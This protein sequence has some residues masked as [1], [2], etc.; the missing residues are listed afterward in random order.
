MTL[1][2]AADSEC[3]LMFI[4]FPSAKDPSWEQKFP[5]KYK[6]KNDNNKNN[7]QSQH[8]QIPQTIFWTCILYQFRTCTLILVLLNRIYP[9]FTNSVDP[10]QKPTGMDLHC[11]SFSI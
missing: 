3:P 7:A 9:A 4:S 8:A 6:S 10:D 1:E 11:L 5:G 2:E